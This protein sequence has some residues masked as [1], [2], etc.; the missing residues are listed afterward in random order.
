MCDSAPQ[1]IKPSVAL[2]PNLYYTGVRSYMRGAPLLGLDTCHW[3]AWTHSG[4]DSNRNADRDQI[5]I[6]ILR[7]I[8]F[9]SCDAIS[10]ASE[11]IMVPSDAGCER[12]AYIFR[13]AF[14]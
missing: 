2:F 9:V 4:I 10:Y 8:I 7:I 6:Y 1:P 14:L 5:Y 3:E 11:Y 13:E 12:R